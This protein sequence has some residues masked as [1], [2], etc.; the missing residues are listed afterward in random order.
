LLDPYSHKSFLEDFF[1]NN[2]KN[3]KA[4]IG[5]TVATEATAT[6]G[7]TVAK[8]SYHQYDLI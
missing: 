3:A 8:V 5:A 7:A 1:Y 6:I 4:I 2:K